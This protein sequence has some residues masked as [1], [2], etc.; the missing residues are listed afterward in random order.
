[1]VAA[2]LARRPLL[3]TG[4]SEDTAGAAATATSACFLNGDGGE[5][6]GT[7]SEESGIEGRDK[8]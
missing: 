6:S 4:V 7:A 1:M 3:P 5:Q 8:L 2:R